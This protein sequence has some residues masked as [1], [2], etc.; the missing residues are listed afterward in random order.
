MHAL[1]TL[2]ATLAVLGTA[3]M[4]HADGASAQ[5]TKHAKPTPPPRIIIERDFGPPR[6]P[7]PKYYGPAPGIQPP[8][9]RVPMP[10]P[11]AEPPTNR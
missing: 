4:A 2:V 11:L 3:M 7:E 9:E 1:Y 6:Q 10:P 5:Q 8:M